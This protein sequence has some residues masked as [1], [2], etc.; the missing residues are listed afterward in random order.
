MYRAVEL[1]AGLAEVVSVRVGVSLR[2]KEKD[3]WARCLP[4]GHSRDDAADGHRE[5]IEGVDHVEGEVLLEMQPARSVV[6]D[7]LHD[8]HRDQ[9]IRRRYLISGKRRVLTV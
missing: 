6:F 5:D 8:I 3:G 1:R 2:R 7:D 9:I 4:L